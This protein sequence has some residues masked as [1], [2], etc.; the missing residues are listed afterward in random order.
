VSSPALAESQSE[1]A[2]PQP[3]TGRLAV[4]GG[5]AR[6]HWAPLTFWGSVLAVVAVFFAGAWERRW[7]ADDGLIVLRTVRNMLAGNG[8]VFNAG[9]RVEANTSTLWTMLIYAAQRVMNLPQIEVV[10]L[11]VALATSMSAVVFAMWGARVMWAGTRRHP[12]RHHGLMTSKVLMLPLGIVVYVV[13]PPARDFATSGLETGLVIAWIALVWLLLQ[14]WARAPH[15]QYVFGIPKVETAFL[16]VVAGL[17]PLVRPELA[18][19]SV[20]ALALIFFAR[21]SILHRAWLVVI[22]GFLPLAYQLWRMSYYGLPYPNTAV[23]KD[24]AGSKWEQG[25]AYLLDLAGPYWLALPMLVGLGAIVISAAW[26]AA[27]PRPAR[28]T[29]SS[30]DGAARRGLVVAGRELPALRSTPVVTALFVVVGVAL[31]LYSVRVGGDFMHGRVL[32]PPLF[33]LL[34]PLAVLPIPVGRQT[35]RDRQWRFVLPVLIGGW[36]VVM[37]W[38]VTVSIAQDPFPDKAESITSNGIVDERAFYLQRTGHKHPLLARDYL[39]FPRMQELI[40]QVRA[41]MTGAVFLPVG[42]AQDRW[43]VVEFDHPLPGLQPFEIPDDPQKTVVFLNLGM[44]SMNLPLDV[45]VYDTVGLAT[46]LAAHTDRMVDGRIGHDKYLPLDWYLADAGVVENPNNYPEW[47][48]PD[49]IEQAKVALTCPATVELRKS[50]TDPLTLERRKENVIN[51]FSYAQYRINRIP[52]Y[53]VQRCGLPM[54]PEVDL[55]AY[56]R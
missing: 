3:P 46:P 29:S 12:A 48:D 11:I 19:V 24:A 42:G 5:F 17:G 13:L 39:D 26:A 37:G 44:T 45:K 22:A 2:P 27:G 20:F 49:W 10:A 47:V 14:R 16:A 4:A 38:A 51:A 56:P 21:S 41:N 35:G 40:T 1:T 53:E 30:A 25:F 7:I 33:T 23:A 6:A 15:S 8:V 55:D 50:Y 36:L 32:L 31:A 52:A 34:L 43:D 18:I 54:P 9:E 28:P